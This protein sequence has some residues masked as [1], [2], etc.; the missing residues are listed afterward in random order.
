MVNRT[1]CAL[2]LVRSTP[3]GKHR[4]GM[5]NHLAASLTE[6]QWQALRAAAE[7]AGLL[8]AKAAA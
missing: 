6:E 2:R 1:C 3:R 5:W 4:T 8:K 7:S